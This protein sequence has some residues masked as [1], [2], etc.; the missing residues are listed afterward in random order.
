MATEIEH[1]YLLKSDAWINVIPDKSYEIRQ[2]YLTKD[3]I[4]TI[5]VR[6][7]GD[8]GYLTIKGKTVGSSRSEYEYEIPYSDALE[9]L[10]DF[11]T[12]LIEKTRHLVTVENKLWEVDEFH[13]LNAGLFIAEIELADENEIYSKP[14]WVGENVTND[15][16]YA[17]SNLAIKPFNAW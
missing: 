6:T 17:N 15:S 12:G 14:E 7:K 5:R 11:C 1:K 13:G 8:K 16:R 10:R 9:L 3:P 4:N 2:G